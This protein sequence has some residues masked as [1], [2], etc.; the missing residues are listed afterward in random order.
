MHNFDRCEKRT[1]YKLI[2][3]EEKGRKFTIRNPDEIEVRV[4]QID[5]CV[6]TNVTDGLRCDWLFVPTAGNV[7]IYVELKGSD[8]G[9]GIK[10][11][12]STI[13]KV[14]E[15]V[16]RTPK[17]CYIVSSRSNP[18]FS[19]RIQVATKRFKKTYA[20]K[21]KVKNRSVEHNLTTQR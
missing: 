7:E 11:L 2:V 21:L 1:R 16:R 6:F 19:T 8:I 10:Q 4:I 14:S 12:E 3:R 5:G 15:N 9:H 17:C 20:A 13:Q 18:A